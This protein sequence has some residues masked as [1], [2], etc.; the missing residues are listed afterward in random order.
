MAPADHGVSGRHRDHG[1]GQ[2][3]PGILAG[4]LS[5]RVLGRRRAG[6]AGDAAVAG[7]LPRHHGGVGAGHLAVGL[8]RRSRLRAGRGLHAGPGPPAPVRPR[9][10]RGARVQRPT[11]FRDRRQRRRGRDGVAASAPRRVP[12]PAGG[13]RRLGAAPV[14]H[15]PRRHR[16]RVGQGPA[17]RSRRQVRRAVEARRLRPRGGTSSATNPPPTFAG[18]GWCCG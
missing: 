4:H 2:P 10:G 11:R 18:P 5:H 17:G 13:G 3:L 15:P 1:G 6:R 16:H 14:R 9:Q 12:D 7:D 8:V